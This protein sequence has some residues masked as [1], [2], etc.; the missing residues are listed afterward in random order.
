MKKLLLI[1]TAV[2]GLIIVP[3]LFAKHCCDAKLDALSKTVL[4][5]VTGADEINVELTSFVDTCCTELRSVAARDTEE[6]G[7][8]VKSVHRAPSCSCET[9]PIIAPGALPSSGSY[10]LANDIAG[11]IN[12]TGLQVKIN[13]NGHKVIGNVIT[14]ANSYVYGGTITETLTV[15]SFSRVDDV[16]LGILSGTAAVGVVA[17]RVTFPVTTTLSSFDS[18]TFDETRFEGNLTIEAIKDLIIRHSQIAGNVATGDGL[19][20][21]YLMYDSSLAG[22][23][24][25]TSFNLTHFGVWHCACKDNVSLVVTSAPVITLYGSVFKQLAIVKGGVVAGMVGLIDECSLEQLMLT[26][27]ANMRIQN[28]VVNAV[29]SG[30]AVVV[31][32]SE[33]MTFDHV[34]AYSAGGGSFTVKG[35]RNILMKQ[36]MGSSPT[37]VIY[38]ISLDDF[39]VA[40]QNINLFECI[41]KNTAGIGFFFG[42]SAITGTVIRCVADN[43]LNRG[44]EAPSDIKTVFSG[45]VS[46]A[47]GQDY[48]PAT[49]VPFNPS[50]DPVTA[51]SWRNIES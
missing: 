5:L 11:T 37:S 16:V 2:I 43:C 22:T 34:Q 48:Q 28:T 41:A 3:A 23:Y 30:D 36:C 50:N 20:E 17:S 19:L 10:C 38:T 46:V 44:F 47:N 14:G 12:A 45:N 42:N 21:K 1:G 51:V 8:E 39:L 24:A 15:G 31:T 35:G 9:T 40:P 29:T 33:Q 27:L 6:R 32:D 13:L 18:I 49:L 26:Q 25:L 7:V 4:D